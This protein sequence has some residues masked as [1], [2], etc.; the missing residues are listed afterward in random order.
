MRK[1]LF[2]QFRKHP[3]R[4]ANSILSFSTQSHFDS[5]SIRKIMI[6]DYDFK[7]NKKNEV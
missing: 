4:D 7:Y 3:I 6:D 5:P 2:A 1:S